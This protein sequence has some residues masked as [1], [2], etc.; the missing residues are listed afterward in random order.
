MTSPN[1]ATTPLPLAP[2]R[3]TLDELHST[4]G[5]AIRHLGISKVRGTF[6]RFTVDTVVGDSLATSSVTA[7]VDVASLDTGNTDRDAHTLSPDLLDVAQRPE[8]RFVSTA[9]RADGDD[10]ALDG[11]LTIGGVTRPLTLALELGGLEQFPMDGSTHAGFEA[12]GTIDRHDYDIQFGPLDIGLGR[13][14]EIVLDIQLVAPA[15]EPAPQA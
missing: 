8:L 13:K 14:V 15:A 3:W 7:V 9:V 5:F 4:V 1:T 12:R 6:E 11:D 2:G 10:W